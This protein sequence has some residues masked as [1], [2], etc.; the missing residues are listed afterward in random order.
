M[1]QGIAPWPQKGPDLPTNAKC[2]GVSY[3][4][5]CTHRRIKHNAD[6]P[7]DNDTCRLWNEKWCCFR[8]C[9]GSITPAHL[10]QA[11]IQQLSAPWRVRGRS[12]ETSIANMRPMQPLCP[13]P[14]L[15]ISFT[16]TYNSMGSGYTKY[17]SQFML[18]L[19][20]AF[21]KLKFKT[22]V[23]VECEEQELL[24][25]PL[26]KIEKVAVSY[27]HSFS[28]LSF[29]CTCVFILM[30]SKG[31]IVGVLKAALAYFSC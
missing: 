23:V 24:A 16:F 7:H 30:C 25:D 28:F 5:F 19:K 11:T 4:S 17:H 29:G 1:P 21:M 9:A 20:L 12:S 27:I 26:K 18:M 10:V 22:L 6:R 3:G 14:W 15:L 13:R 8:W 2:C 31:R